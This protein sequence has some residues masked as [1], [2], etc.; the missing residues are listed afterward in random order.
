LRFDPLVLR[1]A[2]PK[3]L[4]LLAP[5]LLVAGCI[6]HL[7][8]DRPPP[9]GFE[10]TPPAEPNPLFGY[11]DAGAVELSEP[12]DTTRHHDILRF[13]FPSTGDN[14]HPRNLVEGQYFRSRTPGAKKLVVVMPIWGTSSYPPS[15]I[16]YGYA[17]RSRGDAHVIWIY[18]TA[19]LFPWDDLTAVPTEPSRSSS[20]CRA[21][22][23]S[24]TAPRSPTCAGC[25]TGP[26]RARKSTP[27]AS[28]SSVS[29]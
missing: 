24:A 13:S 23:P 4:A 2:L 12:I 3:T 9:E 26:R 11:E 8:Y 21:T 19:P 10:Y 1:G 29:A 20:R 14:G 25:S 18:G 7:H 17:R 22:A 28:R 27:R 15:K 16:S 5:L 6:A